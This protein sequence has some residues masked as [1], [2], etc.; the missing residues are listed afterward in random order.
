[1]VSTYASTVSGE[2]G[3]TKSLIGSRR[4]IS[5]TGIVKLPSRQ[6]V[7]VPVL[8]HVHHGVDQIEF[9]FHHST[10]NLIELGPIV[11]DCIRVDND[12]PGIVARVCGSIRDR[13]VFVLVAVEDGSELILL[14][15]G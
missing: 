15:V 6:D 2:V 11:S 13:I 12:I 14:W 1:M 5:P 3:L 10:W 4:D 8:D 9:T 7:R